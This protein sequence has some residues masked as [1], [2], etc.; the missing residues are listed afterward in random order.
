MAPSK[1]MKL[2]LPPLSRIVPPQTLKY[3]LMTSAAEVRLRPR[4]QPLYRTTVRPAL[5]PQARAPA[6]NSYRLHGI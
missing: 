2:P 1:S 4:T 5:L 6:Y 3:R